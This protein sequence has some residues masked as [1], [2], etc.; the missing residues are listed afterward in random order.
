M[1][2]VRPR[3]ASIPEALDDAAGSRWP[4]LLSKQL[5]ADYLSVD[6]QQV[7]RL[8]AAGQLSVVKLPAMRHADGRA[9]TGTYRRVL[10]DRL[11]LDRLVD[12]NRETIGSPFG[13]R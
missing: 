9:T 4:R 3:A 13:S 1:A 12:A 10:I 8:I 2:V 5:A 6:I 7:G 11:E